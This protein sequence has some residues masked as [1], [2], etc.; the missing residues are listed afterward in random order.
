VTLRSHGGPATAELAALG[1][2]AGDVLDFSVSTNPYGPAAAVLDAIRAA[3]V[4]CYPDP[5]AT[6]A[7]AR[8]AATLD[9][10]AER[11]AVGNG[12]A[13]LLWALARTLLPAGSTV[14]VVEPAFGEL[15]AAA[16]AG[17][18]R[19]LAWHARPED[20]FRVDL[21]AIA[22]V[23]RASGARALYLC[24][25]GVPAGTA[26]PVADVAALAR[27]LPDLELVLDQSFLALSER[28][29]DRDAS[30]P[31][32][33]TRVRSLTKEHNIPGVRVGY[34]VARPDLL[35]ALER[36]R[37]S[38]STSAPAL[39]ATIAACAEEDFVATS[40]TRLLGDRRQLETGLRAL[41]LR[42]VPSSANFLIVPVGDAAAVRPRLLVGRRILVRDCT[43]FGLPDHIRLAAR[44]SADLA[45]LLAALGDRGC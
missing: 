6:A 11:V 36:Q 30:V 40:R 19:V 24:A 39:A 21:D 12:A 20:G 18:A 23:A 33:V 32:N 37:P 1:L 26:V 42:P 14:L 38:W 25:P 35:A 34:A 9:L 4:T 10:P 27:T 28:A 17:G 3:P 22:G 8:L 43:S 13:D 7:R 31:D 44:P 45:R 29:A 15:R 41:G 16:E 2:V 5:A